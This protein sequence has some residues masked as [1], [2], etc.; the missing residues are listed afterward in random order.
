[1]IH[2]EYFPQIEYSGELA[3]NLLV[4]G[5]IRDAI[6]NNSYVSYE[7]TV[8]DTDKP[9]IVSFKYYGNVSYTWA[10]FYANDIFDPLEQWPLTTYQFNRFVKKKFGST[11]FA[12]T[13]VNHYLLDDTYI[14]DKKTFDD[15]LLSADRKKA[16][17]VYDHQLNLNE[18]KRNI[19]IV[20]AIYIRQLTNEL[21]NLFK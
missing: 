16:V 19:K 7:Y 11:E 9:E 2:F 18:A 12:K 13:T 14:I 17:S 1:M 21:A 3:T 5:K 4:R 10:I 15:P 20:D 8:K 6:K